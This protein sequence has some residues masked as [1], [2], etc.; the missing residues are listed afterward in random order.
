MSFSR[1]PLSV[2]IS[3][4]V[5][6]LLAVWL[7]MDLSHWWSIKEDYSFG[8]LVPLFCAYVIYDRWPMIARIF[9]PAPK[10]APVPDKPVRWMDFIGTAGLV[11]SAFVFSLGV[12]YKGYTGYTLPG[13]FLMTNGFVGIFLCSA[14]AFSDRRAD[15]TPLDARSR[16]AFVCLLIFPALVWLISAP[17]MSAIERMV[18]VF[19]LNKVTA[20]VFGVFDML[21][22]V[23]ERRANVLVLP[24]G[25]VGVE[26]A[27]SGIRSLTGCLFA[28]SFLAAVFL[29]RFWKKALM[30]LTALFLAFV[31]NL[32]RGLFLT[33]WAYAYGAESIQGTVH[34]VAGYAVLGVTVVLL[35]CLL[36]IFNFKLPEPPAELAQGA[37]EQSDSQGK[38][39]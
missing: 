34:D 29:D 35:L 25:E 9:E 23:I 39:S 27:C 31:T 4:I 8:Y 10:A 33:A 32:G 15:G 28:G 22:M 7:V 19:L 30:V 18:S 16:W 14:L 3:S 36:P 38:G 12:L 21:G 5:C 2:R 6:V 37:G 26:D 13:S 20:V 1:L 11:F 17:L 24:K